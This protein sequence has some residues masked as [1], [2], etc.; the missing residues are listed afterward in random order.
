M[1]TRPSAGWLALVA[2][3]LVLGP[4]VAAT[5]HGIATR[6]VKARLELAEELLREGPSAHARSVL[7]DAADLAL[8]LG[9]PN[10]LRARAVDRLADLDRLEGRFDDAGARYE[11]SAEMWRVLLGEQ[12]PRLAVTLHNLGAVR[13]A[14]G[15][16]DDADRAF[17]AALPIWEST[18]GADSAEA[19]NTRTALENVR[20]LKQR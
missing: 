6:E 8:R 1:N 14:Q 20:L 3:G 16:L 9:E 18:L 5:D 19:A 12:Q 11:R 7:E 4:A 17:R 15:R 10:L 13:L 2:A